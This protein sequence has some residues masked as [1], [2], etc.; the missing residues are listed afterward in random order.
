MMAMQKETN[1]FGSVKETGFLSTTSC[2]DE[3]SDSFLNSLRSTLCNPT[4]PLPAR[5]RALFSLRSL[6]GKFFTFSVRELPT[7]TDEL[8]ACTHYTMLRN[9]YMCAFPMIINHNQA[10]QS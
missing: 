9:E 4:E 7:T 5:F 2:D 10:Q 6:P 3:P 8:V 1:T